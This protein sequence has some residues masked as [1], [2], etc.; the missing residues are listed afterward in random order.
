MQRILEFVSS[1]K[2]LTEYKYKKTIPA[3]ENL[4]AGCT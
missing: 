1:E 4:R 2:G 3:M